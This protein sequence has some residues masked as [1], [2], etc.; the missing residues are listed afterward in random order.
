MRFSG[1]VLVQI[2]AILKGNNKSSSSLLQVILQ[3]EKEAGQRT[4]M[5]LLIFRDAT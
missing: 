5:Y 1:A 2:N 3:T 4:S